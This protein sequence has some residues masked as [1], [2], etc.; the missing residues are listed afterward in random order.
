MYRL[1]LWPLVIAGIGLSSWAMVG[2]SLPKWLFVV[3]LIL[4][5]AAV[6]LDL[7]LCGK[8]KIQTPGGRPTSLTRGR[9]KIP[10]LMR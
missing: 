3:P 9:V 6:R 8:D 4:V 1:W 10:H 7:R 5:A 2:L